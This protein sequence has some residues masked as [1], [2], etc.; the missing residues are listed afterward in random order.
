MGDDVD[1]LDILGLVPYP[2]PLKVKYPIEKYSIE[3][4]K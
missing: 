2:K 4:E 1:R 3:L